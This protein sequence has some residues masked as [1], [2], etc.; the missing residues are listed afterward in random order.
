MFV[1][2][3]HFYHAKSITNY[4]FFLVNRRNTVVSIQNSDIES[5]INALKVSQTLKKIILI[6]NDSKKFKI[7]ES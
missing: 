2:L 6:I 4:L 5:R 7:L 1:L 3:C